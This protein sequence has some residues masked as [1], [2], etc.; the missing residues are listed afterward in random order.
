[1]KPSLSGTIRWIGLASD[2]LQNSLI[3]SRAATRPL[4]QVQYSPLVLG[5]SAQLSVA[6]Q[7]GTPYTLIVGK[8]RARCVVRQHRVTRHEP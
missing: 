7:C 6:P 2:F 1:M 8:D 4:G 3:K 5:G